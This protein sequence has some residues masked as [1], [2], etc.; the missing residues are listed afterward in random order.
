MVGAGEGGAQSVYDPLHDNVYACMIYDMS[1]RA[2]T[3]VRTVFCS[4]CRTLAS[5]HPTLSHLPAGGCWVSVAVCPWAPEPLGPCALPTCMPVDCIWNA[6]IFRRVPRSTFEPHPPIHAY[7]RVPCPHVCCT[8]VPCTHVTGD[9]DVKLTGQFASNPPANALSNAAPSTDLTTS[10]ATPSLPSSGTGPGKPAADPP[11]NGNGNDNN[12]NGSG[13]SNGND[14]NDKAAAELVTDPTNTAPAPELGPDQQADLPAANATATTNTSPVLSYSH[15]AMTPIT[16]T[17]VTD[18]V[19]SSASGS[20]K[21]ADASVKVKEGWWCGVSE[22]KKGTD[23][24]GMW[25][26]AHVPLNQAMHEWLETLLFFILLG[27]GVCSVMFLIA[28]STVN[29]QPA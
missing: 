20:S 10:A 4:C 5:G 15:P 17:A 23:R 14:N 6:H 19:S 27:G 18:L 7:M 28:L 22:V 21:V 8:A 16:D 11:S 13:N 26:V 24:R 25:C 12:G 9:K 29:R 1:D 2:H 3:F